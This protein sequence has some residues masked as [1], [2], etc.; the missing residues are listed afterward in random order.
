MASSD[1]SS[2]RCWTAPE[3][4]TWYGT[5]GSG[6]AMDL[7]LELGDGVIDPHAAGLLQL[8][9]GR[10]V[11]RLVEGL[12]QMFE[13]LGRRRVDHPIRGLRRR[14][15]LGPSRLCCSVLRGMAAGGTGVADGL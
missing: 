1:S 4:S 11:F 3:T 7:P 12:P 13:H 9:H 10:Q 15:R 2:R 14:R 6:A 8:A 5:G